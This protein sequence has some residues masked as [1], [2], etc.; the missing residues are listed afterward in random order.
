MFTR[1]IKSFKT[2]YDYL[3]GLDSLFFLYVFFPL[4][5]FSGA[6]L[7]LNN[8]KTGIAEAKQ[9]DLMLVITCVVVVAVL[10]GWSFYTY[11]KAVK[12]EL[13]SNN[14]KV[15]KVSTTV[16]TTVYDEEEE[17]EIERVTEELK[18]TNIKDIR[19]L[20]VDYRKIGIKLYQKHCVLSLVIVGLF[21]WTNIDMFGY[22][23]GI[24]VMII[25]IEKPTI[26][27]LSK[28]LQLN[29]VERDF[30]MDGNE[31]PE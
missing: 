14:T 24:L 10:V 19:N 25:S 18:D 8:K 23:Y 5:S 21:A 13:K 15:I 16:T 28:K 11:Y 1:D 6:Y 20:L 29:K 4:L 30:L 26:P 12:N 22:F 17:E 2:G 9:W 7:A 27:R 3:K 31:L